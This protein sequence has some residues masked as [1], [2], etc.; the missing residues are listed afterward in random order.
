MTPS[1][2]RR[3]RKKGF[4]RFHNADHQILLFVLE[5]ALDAKQLPEG[6]TFE[7]QQ[8]AGAMIAELRTLIVA[9]ERVHGLVPQRPRSSGCIIR[10]H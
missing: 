4:Q 8:R 7:E 9:T 5:N 3:L 2:R 6:G 1:Q 10:G